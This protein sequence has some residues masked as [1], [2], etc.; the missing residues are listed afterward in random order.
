MPQVTLFISAVSSEF[1]EDPKRSPDRVRGPGDY[2]TYLRDK[3]TCPDVC[4]KVQEDFIA[5]GVL[6]LDKLAIYI[7]Q[8]DAVIH[9]VG[10]MTGAPASAPAL[11]AIFA[12]E[13]ELKRKL[14]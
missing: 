11:E 8:C 5:G 9:L 12:A 2:R 14:P 6:T 10:D 3:L 4:V 7:K 1:A 13:P